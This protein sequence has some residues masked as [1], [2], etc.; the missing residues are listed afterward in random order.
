[1]FANLQRVVRPRRSLRSEFGKLPSALEKQLMSR[2]CENGTA[3]CVGQCVNKLA[4]REEFQPI[5]VT[6]AARN[7]RVVTVVLSVG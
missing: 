4:L 1:M 3:S 5:A 6:L 7:R 2:W